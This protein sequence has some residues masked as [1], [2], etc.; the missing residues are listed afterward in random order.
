MTEH[1]LRDVARY[2][3]LL[4]HA[5][6]SVSLTYGEALLLYESLQDTVIDASTARQLHLEI[7]T[8]VRYKQLDAKYAIDA[9][10]LISKLCSYDDLQRMAIVDAIEKSGEAT[11]GAI[12]ERLSAAGLRTVSIGSA[13]DAD[14]VDL[15][16]WINNVNTSYAA[17]QRG[18]VR[19]EHV[20]FEVIEGIKPD[21]LICTDHG[22]AWWENSQNAW[23]LPDWPNLAQKYPLLPSQVVQRASRLS[24]GNPS[25]ITN[26]LMRQGCQVFTPKLCYRLPDDTIL[27]ARWDGD[28]EWWFDTADG[29][30]IVITIE[31]N[32]GI[33]HAEL[34]SELGM[35]SRRRWR[36]SLFSCRDLSPLT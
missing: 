6:R 3:D 8:A 1:D 11:G 33:L 19:P 21:L 18:T 26:L 7:Q 4:R 17:E 5:L 16:T 2:R 14:T 24:H 23:Q 29:G 31:N 12:D 27:T 10:T 30:E 20:L 35:G 34:R 9:S 13:T 22:W 36:N 28:V 25:E 32:T 15:S